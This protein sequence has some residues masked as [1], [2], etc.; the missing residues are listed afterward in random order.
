[1]TSPRSSFLAAPPLLTLGALALCVLCSLYCILRPPILFYEDAVHYLSLGQSLAQGRGFRSDTLR[2]PDLMQPPLYPALI[3][4]LMRLGLSVVTAAVA[5]CVASQAL[6]VLALG[7]LSRLCF[8]AR[9]VGLTLLIAALY[10]NLAFGAALV[11]EP[12]FL[13]WLALAVGLFMLSLRASDDARRSLLAAAGAGLALG[14][15][16]LTRPEAVITTA[17]LVLLG[18]LWPAPLGRRLRA[19]GALGLL[20]A[21]VLLPY[22]L[23]L[24]AQ[25]GVFELIPKV[26]YNTALADIAGRLRWEP[27]EE[28]LG[29]REQRVFFTLMPDSATFVMN[30]AFEHP[31]ADPGAYFPLQARGAGQEGVGRRLVTLL[32]DAREVLT[33]GALRTLSFHPLALLLVALA[34]FAALRG[35]AGPDAPPLAPPQ[36]AGAAGTAVARWRSPD[37]LLTLALL[38][39]CGLH[40]GPAVLSGVDYTSRY[41][42]ASLLFSVPLVSRG[43]SPIVDW[44]RARGA[45]RAA[46]LLWALILFGY[47]L[48]T[49]RVARSCAGGPPGWAR[50][51]AIEGAVRQH[52]PTGA[53]VLAEH[54]RYAFLNGG[55]AIQLPYLRDP[56]ELLAFLAR[57]R[58]THALIDSRTLQRNPSR[59]ARALRDPAAWPPSF[60]LLSSLSFTGDPDHPVYLVEVRDPGR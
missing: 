17:V 2:F 15:A 22:G 27:G 53:R 35:R 60:R 29:G 33:D 12:L 25:L 6:T 19:L 26:R 43:T 58:V 36:A 5:L 10:P 4:L 39:L 1:M 52:I 32:R 8:G 55:A 44:L 31:G 20:L 34:V 30:H 16:L 37:A 28:A 47:G 41:L 56:P 23:W 59:T 45:G 50:A 24:K 14:L 54:G 9:G 18:L 3:A 46:C 38:L 21:L 42:A 48:G 7:W 11:L 57:H 13:L 40:L 51:R 49:A